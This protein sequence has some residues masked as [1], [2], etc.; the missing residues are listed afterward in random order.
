MAET[1]PASKSEPAIR[2]SFWMP[3]RAFK[4]FGRNYRS[5]FEGPVKMHLFL[6]HTHWDHI[7][8]LPF[9]QLA[10]D[11]GND[12]H[13]IGPKREGAALLECLERQMLPPISPC[14]FPCCRA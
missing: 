11:P 8:G 9:F 3:E 14:R 13:I 10:Y 4:A 1:R 7:Q 5:K 12:I 6:T 2:Y